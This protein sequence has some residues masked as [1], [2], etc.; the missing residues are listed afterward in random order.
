[1]ATR[2]ELVAALKAADAAGDQNSAQKFAAAI[3]NYSDDNNFQP[4][5]LAPQQPA[6][7]P[8]PDANEVFNNLPMWQKPLQ[9]TADIARRIENGATLGG[10]DR[11]AGAI[12]PL[13]GGSDYAGQK[14]V[15]RQ[16]RDRTGFVGNTLEA[17]GSMAP[18][19]LTGGSTAAAN[20]IEAFLP[21]ALAKLGIG[22]AEG[23]GYGG[24]SS[25]VQGGDV[26]QGMKN[27][28]IAGTVGQGLA[29]AL[30]K[31]GAKLGDMYDTYLGGKPPRMT[32]GGL[33]AAKNQAYQDVAN[34]GVEYTPGSIRG[35]L[36]D[37]DNAAQPYPGRHDQVIAAKNQV[38]ANI[39]TVPRPV[40]L[41]EV[42]LNR[43]IIKR[44]VSDLPD[45]AQANMGRDISKAMDDN[46][47]NVPP[48]GVTARSG[49][50]AAGL[51]MLNNARSLNQRMRKLEDMN[52][53]DYKA[54]VQSA[55]SVNTGVDQTTRN[56]LAGILTDPK[57]R[58]G[59][60][61]DETSQMEDIVEGT[62]GQKI[63]RQ[64][65]RFAPGGGLSW[66]GA[67][68]GTAAA[69]AMHGGPMAMTIAG[70]APAAV[71]LAARGLTARSTT[72]S[73]QGLL[74]T[75]AAGGTRAQPR[76][77]MDPQTRDTLGKYLMMMQL[78]GQ[79]Q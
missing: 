62:P 68:A 12:G 34:A 19:A 56:Q 10:F 66:A 26:T 37:M 9:A 40:T 20:G 24:I 30:S 63:G 78:Q 72:R 59:Y 11:L 70:L 17:A 25:V 51:D 48:M 3:T 54:W 71:G 35:L 13:I 79:R 43:Q 58:R 5:D 22:A 49:D 61:P 31:T 28:A 42:D 75:V 47:A 23:A 38:N 45:R 53:A 27:G 69:A 29:G 18:A 73:M 32:V 57:K 39:G 36:S 64:I 8:P 74:D 7:A 76:A 46:L 41:P 52:A 44:D 67:G 4:Q 65:G 33:E 50:P 1:M 60:T 6:A 21:R 16:A 55:K 2:D 14:E 77:G 15:S